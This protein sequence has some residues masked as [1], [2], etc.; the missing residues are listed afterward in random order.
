MELDIE[1]HAPDAREIVLAGVEEH[2]LE[3]L[4]GGVHG[5][6]IAGAKLAVDFE[7][8]VVLLLDAVLAERH[9]DDVAHVVELGEE[10]V[11]VGDLGFDQLA[12]DG[13]RQ[14]VIG[15]DQHLAGFH[16]DHVGGDV[17]AFQ[18][19]RRDL[20]LLDLG[21]LD[22]FEDAVGDLAALR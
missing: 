13:R 8:R 18:I 11:E 9:G 16:V 6:R 3:Q 22:F 12:D 17:G 21:L 10:H 14:L 19:V 20:H 2:A 4:R 1:L 15:L 5:G 7:Q